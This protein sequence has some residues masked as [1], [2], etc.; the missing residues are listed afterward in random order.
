MNQLPRG[1]AQVAALAQQLPP[2]ALGGGLKRHRAQGVAHLPEQRR[3]MRLKAPPIALDELAPALNFGSSL[4]AVKSGGDGRRV[5][6]PIGLR[7]LRQTAYADPTQ[8]AQKAPHPNQQHQ[9]GGS[10]DVTV[11]IG[12][13]F[14]TVSSLAIRTVSRRL[15]LLMMFLLRILLGG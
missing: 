12:Q 15:D 9:R 13:R 10:R 11:V 7:K 2:E 5:H 6:R 4:L 14:Q 8:P 1:A 3:Q